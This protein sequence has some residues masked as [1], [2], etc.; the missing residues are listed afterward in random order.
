MPSGVE[1]R[2]ASDQTPTLAT[3]NVL[4]KF[5]KRINPALFLTVVPESKDGID[6]MGNLS[7][8]GISIYHSSYDSSVPRIV[9]AI[10]IRISRFFPNPPMHDTLPKTVSPSLQSQSDL[11]LLT[12]TYSVVCVVD[13]EPKP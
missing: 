1:S 5:W 11:R 9:H 2:A 12:S 7:R 13:D 6:R 3:Y 4:G 10:H 8:R